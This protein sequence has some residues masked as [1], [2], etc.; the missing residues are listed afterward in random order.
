MKDLKNNLLGA[1]TI[2]PQAITSNATTTGTG[3]DLRGYEGALV[4]LFSGTIAGSSSANIHTP[5]VQESDSSDTG[6][7]AVANADLIG[8]ESDAVLNGGTDSTVKTIGYIGAKRYIRVVD[9]TTAF[10]T[11]GGVIGALII[12]GAAHAKPAA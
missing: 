4:V 7:T 9:T 3:V 1:V 12:K 2:P 8:L 11:A 6:F 5:E 10:T